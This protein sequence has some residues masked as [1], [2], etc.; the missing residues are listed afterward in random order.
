MS[1]R[2][3]G[4]PTILCSLDGGFDV[5]SLLVVIV[6]RQE[7]AAALAP[8]KLV[9]ADVDRWVRGEKD[10]SDHAPVWAELAAIN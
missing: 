5:A 4:L 8:A 2:G 6:A 3:I 10:A 7:I 1:S 9:A